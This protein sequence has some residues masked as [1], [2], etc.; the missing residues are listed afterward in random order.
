VTLPRSI[1]ATMR[2]PSHLF[3]K[4]Q[5]GSSKGGQRGQHGLERLGKLGLTWHG[6]LYGKTCWPSPNNS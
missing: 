2:K 3:S 6:S 1:E 5:A 4:A